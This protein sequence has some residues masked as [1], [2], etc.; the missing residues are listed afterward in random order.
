M[1]TKM[2][3]KLNLIMINQSV[4]LCNISEK[5][6][7]FTSTIVNF[8]CSVS[9]VRDGSMLAVVYLHLLTLIFKNIEAVN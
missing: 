4:T 1:L 9:S 8:A 5:I 7:L 2:L 6:Y 3:C